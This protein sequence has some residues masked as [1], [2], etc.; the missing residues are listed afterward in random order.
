M[1]SKMFC[2]KI[3]TVKS[4]NIMKDAKMKSKRC[5]ECIRSFLHT[6]QSDCPVLDDQD[7]AVQFATSHLLHHPKHYMKAN[8]T[9]KK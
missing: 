5:P 7:K 4:Y 9:Q 8:Q 3:E 2:V 1:N 6:K